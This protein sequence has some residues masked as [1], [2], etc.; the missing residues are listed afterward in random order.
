MISID[1]LIKDLDEIF[2]DLKFRV[3][4]FLKNFWDEF[5]Y[6]VDKRKS[7]VS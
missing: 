5:E 6:Y 2:Q 7:L 4:S 3:R 1:E